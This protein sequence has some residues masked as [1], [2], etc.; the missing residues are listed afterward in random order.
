MHGP[1]NVGMSKKHFKALPWMQVSLTAGW[2]HDSKFRADAVDCTLKLLW[3]LPSR[4]VIKWTLHNLWECFRG[5]VIF[6]LGNTYQEVLCFL[7]G[8]SPASEF[9]MPT[10]RNTLSQLHRPMETEQIEC[11]ETSAYKIQTPGNYPEESIQHSEHGKSLK[12]RR[13]TRNLIPVFD[14]SFWLCIFKILCALVLYFSGNVSGYTCE[15][16]ICL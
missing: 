13:H 14:A 15:S 11:S 5:E 1:L 6:G 12:S 10:F 4:E 9:Y 8:N 7:L 3:E 2:K 16:R